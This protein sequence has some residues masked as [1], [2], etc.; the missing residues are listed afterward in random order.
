MTLNPENFQGMP[1]VYVKRALARLDPLVTGE[2][3][4]PRYQQVEE[5][6]GRPGAEWEFLN[7]SHM[8]EMLNDGSFDRL[9]EDQLLPMI[10]EVLLLAGRIHD[11]ETRG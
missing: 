6:L 2:Q 4:D 10:T 9:G 8:A 5:L 11:E 1:W 3:D 7:P